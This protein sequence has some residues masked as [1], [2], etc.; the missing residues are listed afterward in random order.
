MNHFKTLQKAII[1]MA[2]SLFSISCAST[3]KLSSIRKNHANTSLYL[4]SEKEIE[5]YG[6]ESRDEKPDQFGGY[7]MNAVK[8]EETGEMT[9]VEKLDAAII[10]SRFRNTAERKGLI[11]FEFM[12]VATDSLQDP[13]WQLRFFPIVRYENGDSLELAPVY[14]TGNDFRNAQITSQNR[15]EKY[16]KGLSRDST[17]FIDHKQ[18]EAFLKRFPEASIDE[19]EVN[20]HYKKPLTIKYNAYK[21]TMAPII[22]RKLI[23]TPLNDDTI[24]TDSTTSA[25]STFVYYYSQTIPSGRNT[26]KF[27]LTIKTLIWNG[28]KV[29]CTLPQTEPITYYVSSLSGL[30]NENLAS[31]H[32]SD[33][34]YSKGI[35]MMRDS[36]W[37]NAL[38]KLAPY[39]DYN[40]ALAYLALEY[41]A[42][43]CAIL[44][45][46]PKPD[47]KS[48]YLMSISYSRRNN[49]EKSL[50]A[51]AKAI[52]L[53]PNLK[54][55]ANLDPE[56][57]TLIKKLVLY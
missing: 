19:N 7:L 23:T 33:S 43:S 37:E 26:H 38:E 54:Y 13:S 50:E 57:A 28:K 27:Y 9:A 39:E 16:L 17:K 5:R 41:N 6:G 11:N 44:E 24:R 34:T 2:A 29:I 42:T 25:D 8:D 4:P 22:K 20:D 35:Q 40:S 47:A 53:Q 32:Q 21:A 45:R 31:I 30:I 48:F 36:D 55:R 52:E 51:L 46:I 14:L 56:T 18:K 15:Y 12:I 1:I 10:V 49:E 3:I